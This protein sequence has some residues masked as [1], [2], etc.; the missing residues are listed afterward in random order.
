MH[1]L[2]FSALYYFLNLGS[3]DFEGVETMV[4]ALAPDTVDGTRIVVLGEDGFFDQHQ[5]S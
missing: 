1:P 5:S 2:Y 3:P 4:L